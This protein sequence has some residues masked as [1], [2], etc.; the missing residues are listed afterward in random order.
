MKTKKAEPRQ[1]STQVRY[2][3]FSHY[4]NCGYDSSLNAIWPFAEMFN[5]GNLGIRHVDDAVV[6]ASNC[7]FRTWPAPELVGS[8]VH[9]PPRCPS[10]HILVTTWQYQDHTFNE[11]VNSRHLLQHVRK[12]IILP[13]GAMLLWTGSAACCKVHCWDW[14]GNLI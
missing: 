13:W 8:G 3:A 9:T 1:M 12:T 5:V 11:A 10:I 14:A 2:C 6:D 7:K 4:P